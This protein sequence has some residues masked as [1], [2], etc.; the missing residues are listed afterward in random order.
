MRTGEVCG[1]TV[2]MLWN[3]RFQRVRVPE[4][5][6]GMREYMVNRVRKLELKIVKLAEVIHND[7]V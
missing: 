3:G 2:K 5:E 6:T 1:Q 4:Q 7:K